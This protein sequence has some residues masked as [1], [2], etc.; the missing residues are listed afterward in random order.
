VQED[1]PRFEVTMN[2]VSKM[3][4]ANSDEHLT[5]VIKDELQSKEEKKKK[6]AVR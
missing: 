3:H 1:I 2:Y 5:K 4:V 6:K